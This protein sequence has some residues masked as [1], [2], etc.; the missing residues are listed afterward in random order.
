M[1]RNIV[2]VAD[3]QSGSVQARRPGDLA[4]VAPTDS[5]AARQVDTYFDRLSKYVPMEIIGSYL[6]VEGLLR[7]LL[8]PEVMLRGLVVLFLLGV[9][10]TWLFTKRVLNVVRTNQ[11]LMSVFAFAVWVFATGGWFA[12]LSFWAPGWGTIAVVVFAVAVR[13]LDIGPL[14]EDAKAPAAT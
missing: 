4:A 3:I 9:V 2:T 11:V 5:Q 6:L 8:Q 13:V 12:H 1:N 14:P 7:E 10:A